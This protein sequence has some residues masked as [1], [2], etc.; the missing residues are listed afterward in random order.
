MKINKFTTKKT[1]I[2]AFARTN[3]ISEMYFIPKAKTDEIYCDYP[4]EGSKSCR[5]LGTFQYYT[6]RLKNNK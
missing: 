5:A 3:K 4:K 6:E 1:P 2:G